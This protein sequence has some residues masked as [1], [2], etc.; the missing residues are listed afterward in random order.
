MIIF[1]SV[2]KIT[3][4]KRIRP[5]S[6]VTLLLSMIVGSVCSAQVNVGLNSP[7]LSWRQID[8]PHYQVIFPSTREND[9]FRVANL[10]DFII[11]NDSFSLRHPK[12]K[13]PIILQNQT[14]ISNGFVSIGPW[15]SEYYLNPPQFQF[16]GITPWLDMLTIHEYRHV[17]QITNA[18]VGFAGKALRG[19]FGQG[20]W[21]FYNR[22]VL[23]RWFLEGDAV[24]AETILSNGGRGRSPDFER[25][26]RAMRLSGLKYNYEKAAFRS[27]KDFVPSHYNLGYHMTTFAR[28]DFGENV[29]DSVLT[30]TYQKPGLYRFSKIVKKQTGLSTKQLYNSAMEDMDRWWLAQDSKISPLETKLITDKRSTVFTNYRFPNYL[31][32]DQLIVQK[33]SLNQIRTIY[34]IENAKE[35]K[36]FIP[37]VSFSEHFSIGGNKMVWSEIRFHPRWSNETYSVLRLYD[38]QSASLRKISSKSKLSAPALSPDGKWIAAVEA[39][40]SGEVNLVILDTNK[41]ELQYREAVGSDEFI[42]FPRWREDNQTIVVVG[43]NRQGNYLRSFHVPSKSWAD[44]T[45]IV[46]ST[47]DRI[48]P[49]GKYVFFSSSSTGVQNIFALDIS[50]TE[51]F[52]ITESRFGAFDPSISPSGKKLAYSEYTANGFR[53]RELVLNDALWKQTVTPSKLGANYFQKLVPKGI[54]TTDTA[55]EDKEHSTSRY[56]YFTKGLLTIHSWYPYITTEEFGAGFFSKNIMS[57]ISITGQVTYNTNENSWKTLGRLSY[58]PFFPIIDLEVSTGQ[59]QSDNLVST[60]D[61]LSII[62]YGGKW[63]EHTVSGGIRLPFNITHGAYPSSIVLS[64]KYRHYK[65][66][67]LDEF[68]DSERDEDFGSVDF[69]FSFQRAQS[70]AL[71][72]IYPRWAQTLSVNYQETVGES[73]NNGEIFTINSSLFF[74]GVVRNH[75]FFLT[76]GYQT[77]E[78]VDAYRFEDVFTNARGYGSRPFESVYRISAN[79]TLPIWYPDLAAGS[80]I[81]FKRLRGNAFYDHSEGELLNLDTTLRSYGVE[82]TFDFR[83]IRLADIGAGIRVGRKIDESDYFAEFFITSIR[84]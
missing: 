22:A 82:L 34:K 69:D 6:V 80:L 27:F 54:K 38:F 29:W 9:A 26:Y 64:S 51:L 18:R 31:S 23:P 20:G 83:I 68:T 47:I 1:D 32:E 4:N 19:V 5:A 72:N 48:F 60:T 28:R 46:E 77:E 84:F 52:Q 35:S 40:S 57:T 14:V 8:T 16:A 62:G 53:T 33:S 37:G 71:Q 25:E 12:V 43:R 36:L 66:D 30:E 55:V 65:V 74:P 24:Y 61:T 44:L 70:K 2:L 67:Y 79:Y 59:R 41:G 78:I 10:L 45:R 58:G 63:K 3:M 56:K 13:I 21:A 75:S 81:Y 15:R 7:K 17:E 73:E 50:T 42:S 49:K 11:A 76:G 39:S